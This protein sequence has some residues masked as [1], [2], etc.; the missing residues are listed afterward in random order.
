MGD[1]E[2][3]RFRVYAHRVRSIRQAEAV[4]IPT[5]L[6]GLASLP[7]LASIRFREGGCLT[8]DFWGISH[9]I[10]EVDIHLGFSRR[11]R[12]PTDALTRYL[13][14]LHDASPDVQVLRLRGTATMPLLCRVSQYTHL[15]A[16]DLRVGSSLPM[17]IFCTIAATFA[18]LRELTVDAR[19]LDAQDLVEGVTSLGTEIF[20]SLRDLT[21][22]AKPALASAL[23]QLIP[24]RPLESFHFDAQWT[25]DAPPSPLHQVFAH[26]PDSLRTVSLECFDDVDCIDRATLRPLAR[27]A[28]LRRLDIQVAVTPCL[29]DQDAKDLAVRWP[30]LEHLA[31]GAVEDICGLPRDYGMTPVAYAWFSRSC[32]ALE[33]LALP[34]YILT[35]A[36]DLPDAAFPNRTPSNLDGRPCTAARLR[37]LDIGTRK[38]I[39]PSMAN[40][41]SYIHTLFPSLTALEVSGLPDID[42]SQQANRPEPQSGLEIYYRRILVDHGFT[43]SHHIDHRQS[44]QRLCIY[45]DVMPAHPR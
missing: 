14:E 42:L 40:F 12:C 15:R 3:A 35:S 37:R 38:T 13:K 26:L 2:L 27:L 32:P 11:H 36:H 17:E 22:Q 33:S 39:P 20:V 6:R 10:R 8:A 28:E 31:I 44:T 23:L 5:A 21:L 43:D 19:H 16:L 24:S 30:N 18:T 45:P 41:G 1:V 9:T 29:D 25:P 4:R 34:V 7:K